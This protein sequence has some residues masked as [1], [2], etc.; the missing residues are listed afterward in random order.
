VI[1]LRGVKLQCSRDSDCASPL[2][3]GPLGVA[4]VMVSHVEDAKHAN[5]A[6]RNHLGHEIARGVVLELVTGWFCRLSAPGYMDCTDWSG[7]FETEQEAR[8]HIAETYDVDP[9]T[10]DDVAD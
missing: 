8:D 4:D 1:G 6:I 9:E 2:E 10:G 5:G 3:C 7:P